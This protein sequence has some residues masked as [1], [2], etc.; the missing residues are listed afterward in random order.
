MNEY[1]NEMIAIGFRHGGTL[2]AIV[3][4]ATTFFFNAPVEQADHADRA[5]ACAIE[6]DAFADRFSKEKTA[7]GLPVGLTR[8]GVHSGPVII[9]NM[10]GDVIFNYAAH[11]DAIN[12]AA[13]LET[14]NK[15]LGTRV[16]V[17]METASRCN[18]F[19]GRPVGTIQLKGK[20]E[21]ILAF[22]PLTEEEMASEH[23]TT[24][25][26]A[27]DLLVIDAEAA[28]EAFRAAADTYPDDP[29]IRFHVERLESGDD[30]TL[31]RM[32]SK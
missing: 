20:A 24:Y 17:S 3:G 23:I 27:Y 18:D 29:L 32:A 25:L 26:T 14:V 7:Q 16:C 6:M 5:L 9:G 19:H 1:L 2:D 10:G 15:H 11:G 21:G 12:V 30:G 4:D 13:R 8:I 22:E 28:L 31:I